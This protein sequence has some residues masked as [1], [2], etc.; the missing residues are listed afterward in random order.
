VLRRPAIVPVPSFALR[1]AVG[2][3]ADAL[4]LASTRVGSTK[5]AGSG[6]VFRDPDLETALRWGLGRVC[7]AQT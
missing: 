6:F 5:L 4:L 1:A 7:A 3:M 2:E